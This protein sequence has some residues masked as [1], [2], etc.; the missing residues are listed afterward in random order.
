[1]RPVVLHDAVDPDS[2]VST[3]GVYAAADTSPAYGVLQGLA[4]AEE[5]REL[6]EVQLE[7]G[8]HMMAIEVGPKRNA[9]GAITIGAEFFAGAKKDYENWKEKWWREAIQN[10]VDAGAT[11]VHCKIDVLDENEQSVDSSGWSEAKFIRVSC[12]DDGVGMTEDTLL[13]KFLVLG[14]SGKGSDPGSVGGF[15]KAKELLL[16]PWVR[17]SVATQRDGEQGVIVEGHGI[18]YDVKPLSMPGRHGTLL[19]VMMAVDDATSD[20]HAISFIEKCYLPKVLFYVNDKPHKAKLKVGDLVR[21]IGEPGSVDA[22][23]YYDKRSKLNSA[24][25]VR[26]GGMYMH[27]KWISS[28]IKGTII[29]ELKGR[30]TELLTANRDGIG[31]RDLRYALDDF[32][33]QLAADTKTAL[34][35]KQGILRE[36]FAGV[37]KFASTIRQKQR[38]ILFAMGSTSPVNGELT[39]EQR[40]AV[41][42]QVQEPS[43]SGPID[44]R[45][46]RAAIAAMMEAKMLGSVQVKALAWHAAWN[47]DFFI[48]NEIQGW[49]VPAKFRPEKMSASIRKLAR[50]WAELCRFVLIQL[51][52][53]G[54][55][56]VGWMF[57]NASAA[58]YQ[59]LD[60]EHWLLLNPFIKGNMEGMGGATGTGEMWQLSNPAHIDS[61]YALA[62]HEATHM[63]DGISYHDESF[64]TAFTWN[65]AKTANRGKQIKKIL[66]AVVSR[67]ARP[68][69]GTGTTTL[70]DEPHTGVGADTG[71]SLWVYALEA[72]KVPGIGDER[73]VYKD[74]DI[75]RLDSEHGSTR[76]LWRNL[77][78]GIVAGLQVVSRD[79]VTATIA[80]VYVMPGWRRMGLARRLLE[81]ARKDFAEVRHASEQHLTPAGKAWRGAVNP[82]KPKPCLAPHREIIADPKLWARCKF[83]GVQKEEEPSEDFPDLELRNCTCGST[84]SRPVT[85]RNPPRPDARYWPDFGNWDAEPGVSFEAAV[86]QAIHGVSDSADREP[87]AILMGTDEPFLRVAT[88]RPHRDW[89]DRYVLEIERLA[90]V[91]ENIMSWARRASSPHS[92]AAVVRRNRLAIGELDEESVRSRIAVAQRATGSASPGWFISEAND[93]LA[94][95]ADDELWSGRDDDERIIDDDAAKLPEAQ[96]ALRSQQAAAADHPSLEDRITTVLD[97]DPYAPNTFAFARE[98]MR[99]YRTRGDMDELE[100]LAIDEPDV[101][102]D[103]AFDVMHEF[104][105]L[106]PGEGRWTWE[107][108]GQAPRYA[109]ILGRA[110]AAPVAP[111]PAPGVTTWMEQQRREDATA[112]EIL[113]RAAILEALQLDIPR[114]TTATRP[115]VDR[116]VEAIA[117]HIASMADRETPNWRTIEGIWSANMAGFAR[118]VYDAALEAGARIDQYFDDATFWV[119]TDS[120]GVTHSMRRLPQEA[121]HE[122]EARAAILAAMEMDPETPEQ[123]RLAHS[124]ITSVARHLASFGTGTDWER[125]AQ[126]S[127]GPSFRQQVH[128]SAYSAGLGAVDVG[129]RAYSLARQPVF[130]EFRGESERGRVPISHSRSV[131]LEPLE[132]AIASALN[133]DIPQIVATPGT[134]RDFIAAVWEFVLDRTTTP[135]EW[136]Y[137]AIA[138][139]ESFREQVR[140]AAGVIGY[141]EPTHYIWAGYRIPKVATRAMGLPPEE[142]IPEEAR[143]IAQAMVTAAPEWEPEPQ[144][145]LLT[146]PYLNVY[147][148]VIEE[149]NHAEEAGGP[150]G[151]DYMELM[152]S[153]AATAASL[154][155]YQARQSAEGQAATALSRRATPGSGIFRAVLAAM[156]MEPTGEDPGWDTQQRSAL[157]EAIRD[158]ARSRADAYAAAGLPEHHGRQAAGA[159]IAR[160]AGRRTDYPDMSE[161]GGNR[162]AIEA[163][164]MAVANRQSLLLI[165]NDTIRAMIARRIPTIMANYGEAPFR[166]PHHTTRGAALWGG[167]GSS[168]LHLAK[169]GV[170]YLSDYEK[171]DAETLEQLAKNAR[172]MPPGE[173]PIIVGGIDAMPMPRRHTTAIDFMWRANVTEAPSATGPGRETSAQIRARIAAGPPAPEDI[174]AM[175]FGQLELERSKEMGMSPLAQSKRLLAQ[176]AVGTRVQLLRT[177]VH[178]TDVWPKGMT[179]TVERVYPERI[180]GPLEIT[181]DDIATPGRQ[182]LTYDLDTME[183]IAGDLEIET[184]YAA[185][186]RILETTPPARTVEGLMAKLQRGTR[187]RLISAVDRFP[188]FVAKAGLTG[189]VVEARAGRLGVKLDKFL[190]GAEDWNNTIWWTEEEEIREL[191]LELEV[192]ADDTEDDSAERFRLLEMN[193]KNN[194]AWVTSLLAKHFEFME[195]QVPAKWLPK[196]S[197]TKAKRGKFTA[198]MKEYGCGAYGCVLPTLDKKVVLKITTD[199]TEYQFAEQLAGELAAQVTVDYHLVA[200]L[201][202]KHRGRWTYLLWRDSAE[203][204]GELDKVV[205][206]EGRDGEA[207]EVYIDTQHKAAQKAYVALMQGEPAKHLIEA[208][209]AETRA[210][211]KNV[212]ELAELADGMITNLKKNKVFMGDVH[213]GNIGLVGDRWLVVDP[214]NIAV[215]EDQ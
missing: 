206:E 201:P 89:T 149:M 7:D 56:G 57:D 19:T 118:Q 179:G 172:A 151:G 207:V 198:A 68:G 5:V 153:I 104:A 164:T 205:A 196:L 176:L 203:R 61:L 90:D 163:A 97:L 95:E 195:E 139:L 59:Y 160:V 181:P 174:T 173:R 76:Y 140:I 58:A 6:G 158:E 18:Q 42:G 213:A 115:A 171:F 39:D 188:N 108:Q 45:P 29:V 43:D 166:A 86:E 186:A 30:S 161:V 67:S 142:E 212:P 132:L 165:G 177:V 2:V 120:A 69:A 50:F 141:E 128:G 170:L 184:E 3:P 145:P 83:I 48:Y 31:K 87:I 34:R 44:L 91:P 111:A 40:Q 54:E 131:Q 78:G 105:L 155:M 8:H 189:S 93:G 197:K 136:R 144:S 137:G 211:G 129:G 183:Q 64:A 33:N 63:A 88:V 15:G 32:Q 130:W 138:N 22:E 169:G 21:T 80:N 73:H 60:N 35:K 20:A 194:P 202:E 47:P 122:S 100:A 14:R 146:R 13:N 96:A 192:I 107:A 117:P 99:R 41:L 191:P 12:A 126:A 134:T 178:G 84:L 185:R 193:P 25:L 53:E 124:M 81:Q 109:P 119:W 79:G 200:G 24:M 74:N 85:K 116:L 167:G 110:R 26:V 10:A 38:D 103:V 16:L 199:D 175:R 152:N 27:E 148:R 55:Y 162:E 46:S 9:A 157:F 106:D 1:M 17:W 62:V 135:R 168:E 102:R 66:K 11:E 156:A 70:E 127:R 215:L 65:V 121:I 28:D 82:G 209:V 133:L 72:G 112:Q 187:V 75:E 37:G 77:D 154:R 51:N 125:I 150:E 204:V 159:A 210:M 143:G 23:V 114:L 180:T 208:W 147:N 36:R 98:I 190:P 214:G 52:Y 113:A 4:V 101:F 123:R 49:R 71:E 92:L 182:V 94:I